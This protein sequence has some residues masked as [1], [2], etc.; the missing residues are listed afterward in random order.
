MEVENMQAHTKLE[1]YCE[2]FDSIKLD[3][4]LTGKRI[5]A[6]RKQKN[7]TQEKLVDICGCTPTH[8][9][10]IENGKIGISCGSICIAFG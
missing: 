9:S 4:M 10:N 6:T 2:E 8:I 7:I 5:K 1:N 3:T